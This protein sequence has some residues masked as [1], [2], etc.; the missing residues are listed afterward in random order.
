MGAPPPYSDD[1][2]GPGASGILCFKNMK[3]IWQITN[4]EVNVFWNTKSKWKNVVFL[5]IF[6][7]LLEHS[8]MFDR[9]YAHYVADLSSR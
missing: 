7:G 6:S 1:F 9:S 4:S 2:F 5:G 3:A 8:R